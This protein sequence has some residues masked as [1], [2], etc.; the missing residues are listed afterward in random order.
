[1]AGA[2]REVGLETEAGRYAVG[3]VA[4][5][6]APAF[7][8]A[9]T[10]SHM[11]GLPYVWFAVFDGQPTTV[12]TAGWTGDG[13]DEIMWQPEITEAEYR[14]G[15]DRIRIALADGETYQV[16]YTQRLRASF[17]SDPEGLFRRLYHAQP[18]EYSA[19]LDTGRFAI[20]CTSPELFF[21]AD[22]RSI[23]SKP[24]KG[25][26]PRGRWAEE[27]VERR[28]G[29]RG[30]PKERAENVMIV[31][32]MRSDLGRIART[33]TVRVPALFETV[34]LPTVWQMTSTVTAE[35]RE[36]IRLEDIFGAA[37]PPGSVTGAPKT[38]T[39]ALIDQL[40]VSPRGVYC[41]AIGVVGLG[42][43]AAFN[44]A[45]RTVVVD[46]VT[47][48]AE[49]GV[50]GGVTWDST[51]GGEYAELQTKSRF[52]IRQP[53]DF[54]LL[55]TMR[56]ENGRYYL[57]DRHLARLLQSADYFGFRLDDSEVAQRLDALAGSLQDGRFRVRLAVSRTGKVCVDSSAVGL[58]TEWHAR[59]A[60]GPVDEL[61]PFLF[62]KTTHRAVYDRHRA[63]FGPTDDA[64]LWNQRGEVTEF[65][66][67]NLMYEL[68]GQLYT[69]TREC[70][71][72]NG[73]LRAEMLEQSSITERRLPVGELAS[74]AALWH[75]NSVRLVTPVLLE[76]YANL[77][78]QPIP[79]AI[80]R[81]LL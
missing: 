33:G 32:L 61:D 62:H 76:G 77:T 51:A 73:T 3:F 68:D 69:P 39:M 56:L 44:V 27:D 16:N 31:D 70:G 71:L 63:G 38:R 6:A 47:G 2:L 72:L 7:D 53:A 12:D 42:R 49:C 48:E 13:G 75:L 17:R 4:Y 24:M 18:G 45:I 8:H 30:S 10:A 36:D 20:L 54:D 11:E 79:A 21:E 1:V 65:T 9:F 50:G 25:T 55:E 81:L 23:T 46:R 37:F 74:C 58:V 41:G 26:A 5:G 29:L 57:L 19:F 14:T 67:G 78:A 34:R 64:L 80:A 59:L 60:D 40:E 52:L 66:L 43:R 35:L 22:G 15:F 28:D